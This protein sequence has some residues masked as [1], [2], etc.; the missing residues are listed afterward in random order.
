MTTSSL[1]GSPAQ[2]NTKLT[3]LVR[4]DPKITLRLR[5]VFIAEMLNDM[6]HAG[7][8]A[9]KTNNFPGESTKKDGRNAV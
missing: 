3:D 1:G 8:N 4:I 9:Q 2:K 5:S 7:K 6:N